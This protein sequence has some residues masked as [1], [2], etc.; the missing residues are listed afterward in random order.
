[1]KKIVLLLLCPFFAFG[2]PKPA[3]EHKVT[4]PSEFYHYYPS[5]DP[6]IR[7]KTIVRKTDFPKEGNIAIWL[8][9]SKN[10]TTREILT[11][12][13]TRHSYRY[14]CHPGYNERGNYEKNVQRLRNKCLKVINKNLTDEQLKDET[15]FNCHIMY[16]LIRGWNETHNFNIRLDNHQPKDNFQET[17]MA[18]PNIQ[19]LTKRH[20]W[21]TI[22]EL[23]KTKYGKNL[24]EFLA[25]DFLAAEKYARKLNSG[26]IIL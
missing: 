3:K 4:P 26:C 10:E 14:Y 13:F 15:F 8:V 19:E 21:N 23:Y 20:R 9:S 25:I 5:T 18:Q 11:N 2:N 6:A 7:E 22:G 17:F 12:Y 24:E 16:H 1:M